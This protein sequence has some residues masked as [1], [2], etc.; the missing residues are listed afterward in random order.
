MNYLSVQSIPLESVQ[1]EVLIYVFCSIIPP[2]LLLFQDTD[3]FV[4]V[5]D[6][7]VISLNPRMSW[8]TSNSVPDPR[9]PQGTA[10]GYWNAFNALGHKVPVVLSSARE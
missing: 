6:R 1:V 3:V 4:D 9:A 8:Q 5:E 2:D 10:D 7:F